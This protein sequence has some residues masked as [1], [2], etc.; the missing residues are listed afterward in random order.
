MSRRSFTRS[1]LVSERVGAGLMRTP[2]GAGPAL[3]SEP[4]G[5]RPG[6]GSAAG[7][8]V[9]VTVGSR[10]AGVVGIVTAGS[11]TAG[12][13]GNVT[14]G[15]RTVGAVG[16]G[17]AIVGDGVRVGDGVTAGAGVRV[18]G[19]LTVGDGVRG[20][21]TVGLGG[22]TAPGGRSTGDGPVIVDDGGRVPL[23]VSSV[24]GIRCGA[25]I[26]DDGG[27]DAGTEPR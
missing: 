18:G 13:V 12:A 9:A 1:S 7:A 8:G 24:V 17:T 11:R 26:I 22:L 2:P 20:G 5:V 10:T 21:V 23:A 19:T 15:S 25:A 16:A 27:R 14:V 6:A 4:G 3:T